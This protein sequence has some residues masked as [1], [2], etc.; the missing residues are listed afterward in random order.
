MGHKNDFIARISE[1]FCSEIPRCEDGTPLPY[2]LPDM[3][4]DHLDGLDEFA[5]LSI[6]HA[7]GRQV[8]IGGKNSRR[9]EYTGN[10][11]IQTFT[12]VDEGSERGSNLAEA[13]ESMFEGRAIEGMTIR[14]SRVHT[15]ET[16]KSSDGRYN[17]LLTDV[18]FAYRQTK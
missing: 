3:S 9:F 12:K 13:F 5:K 4:E 18:F 1:R 17:T 10:I 16:G 2:A 11:F 15:R 8:T 6:R 7:A 14:F